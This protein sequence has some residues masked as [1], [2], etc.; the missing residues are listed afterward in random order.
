ML[1][2]V[3]I[4]QLLIILIIVVAIFGTKK[5]RGTGKDLGSAVKDFRE[6]MREGENEESQQIS[7]NHT[8]SNTEKQ[9]EE[10]K[11]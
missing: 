6:A 2:G 10:D 5:L 8:Q 7:S 9:A 4:W 11:A 1:A 3:S